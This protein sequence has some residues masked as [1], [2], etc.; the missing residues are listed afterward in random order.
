RANLNGADL[1]GANLTGAALAG[2]TMEGANFAD[3]EGAATAVF[4]A[5]NAMHWATGQTL[6]AIAADRGL[7]SYNQELEPEIQRSLSQ[8]L[9]ATAPGTSHTP[10]SI[11]WS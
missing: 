11:S 7:D 5:R 4:H 8:G 1:S 9:E 2:A 6:K 3:V 10:A